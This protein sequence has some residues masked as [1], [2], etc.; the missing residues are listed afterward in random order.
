MKTFCYVCR[1]EK[2]RELS[3]LPNTYVG[4]LDVEQ[5]KVHNIS[6]SVLL[7]P[8]SI[9]D[10]HVCGLT[11]LAYKLLYLVQDQIELYFEVLNNY[12]KLVDPES[13]ILSEVIKG[14]PKFHEPRS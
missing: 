6:N 5:A 10:N 3:L 7:P 11:A 9:C 8:G 1:N 14:L 4:F 13:K 2:T 12:A